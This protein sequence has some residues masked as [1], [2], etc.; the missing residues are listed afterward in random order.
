MLPDQWSQISHRKLNVYLHKYAE[1]NTIHTQS[2]GVYN[3]QMILI[4][5]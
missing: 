2:D 5:Y 4:E 3:N 1:Q